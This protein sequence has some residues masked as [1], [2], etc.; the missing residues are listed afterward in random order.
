MSAST[1]QC[2]NY[3]TAT[4]NGQGRQGGRRRTVRGAVTQL[5]RWWDFRPNRMMMMRMTRRCR[6]RRQQRLLARK[7]WNKMRRSIQWRMMQCVL[8]IACYQFSPFHL[9][10]CLPAAAPPAPYACGCT[11]SF[12]LL[13]SG[14]FLIIPTS[15]SSY[16]DVTAVAIIVPGAQ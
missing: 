3:A 13:G 10:V 11:S 2:G 5:W 14:S 9:S 12:V 16:D 1:Q 15:S 8:V 4:D 6:R 7:A